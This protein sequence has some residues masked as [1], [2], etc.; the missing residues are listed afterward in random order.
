MFSPNKTAADSN[1]AML[2]KS[3]GTTKSNGLY[4]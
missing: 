1:N 2:E 4:F 3:E